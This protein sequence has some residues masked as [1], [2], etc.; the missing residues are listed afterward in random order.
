VFHCAGGAAKPDTPTAAGMIWVPSTT[1][2]PCLE[3]SAGE[4]TATAVGLP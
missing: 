1:M 3:K 4:V 2:A